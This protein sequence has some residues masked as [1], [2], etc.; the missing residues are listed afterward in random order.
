MKIDSAAM[1]G[2]RQVETRAATESPPARVGATMV[3]LEVP[4]H[5]KG[6]KQN[7]AREAADQATEA[8]YGLFLFGGDDAE[9]TATDL[10]FVYYLQE[11]K[12]V[13]PT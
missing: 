13:K 3:C 8:Q 12:W 2:W 7:E 6:L 10:L 11:R 4:M 5:A 1:E 9:G